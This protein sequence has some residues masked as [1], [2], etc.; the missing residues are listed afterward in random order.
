MVG[1]IH[2]GIWLEEISQQVKG[3]TQSI[4]RVKSDIISKMFLKMLS[5]FV[6]YTVI[7]TLTFNYVNMVN[8]IL[9]VF[10]SRESTL[11]ILIYKTIQHI[12][13]LAL[14]EIDWETGARHFNQ[15]TAEK[16]KKFE[17]KCSCSSFC[18]V[19]LCSF[20]VHCFVFFKIFFHQSW[21]TLNKI[22]SNGIKLLMV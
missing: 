11:W 13:I 1:Q 6:P 18:F 9:R 4:H 5:M 22:S 14:S 21:P 10:F 17:Q 16:C 7:W 19:S 8:R 15:I 3:D 2:C 20:L 12:K